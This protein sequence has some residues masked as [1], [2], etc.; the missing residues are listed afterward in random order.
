MTTHGAA[1]EGGKGARADVPEAQ[2]S[3]STQ[4]RR[5]DGHV[6]AGFSRTGTFWNIS[7]TADGSDP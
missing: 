1:A 2:R 4:P 3:V 7:Y 5:E 6:W